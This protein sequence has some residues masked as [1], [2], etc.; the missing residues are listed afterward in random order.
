MLHH[1]V[2]GRAVKVFPETAHARLFTFVPPP[3]RAM[4]L[5]S[6][7]A[8]TKS[9][10]ARALFAPPL[11]RS[12]SSSPYG[13]THVWKRRKPALPNPLVPEFPQRVVRA[14]GSSFTHWTTSPRSSVRLTRDVSNHP[15]WN[16]AEAVSGETEEEAGAAGRLGRFARRFG[17]GMGLGQEDMAWVGQYATESGQAPKGKVTPKET[18]GK[19]RK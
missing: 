2:L 18:S 11:A 9:C 15:V 7:L 4:S 13:R 19:K 1:L 16:P 14:D 6:A 12:V 10:T 5:L 3:A 8:P 17:D